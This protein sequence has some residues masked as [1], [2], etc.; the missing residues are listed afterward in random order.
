[1]PNLPTTTNLCTPS[2]CGKFIATEDYLFTKVIF[3]LTPTS[4]W[5]PGAKMNKSLSESNLIDQGTSEPNVT[6][7]NFVSNRA[8]KRKEDERSP[9]DLS[10]SSPSTDLN[11]FCAFKEE[12]RGMFASLLAAQR[13]EFSNINPTLMKIQETNA[14]IETSIEY[15]QK[16]NAEL[17]KKIENLEQQKKED[18]K[19]I[20]VLEEKIENMQKIYRKANIEIKNV[21][22]LEKETKDDL[23]KYTTSLAT[24]VGASI[25]KS[26]IKDIYRVRVQK[27]TVSNAP[28]VV[29]L[30]STLLKS[31]VLQ[32]CKAFNT[33]NKE[34]LRAKHL[35]FVVTEETAVFVS[36]QLTPKASRLYFLARDLIKSTNFTFCWTAYGNVYVR[37]NENSPI[38]SITNEA[39]IKQLFNTA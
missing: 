37:K 17:K 30:T 31:D 20:F 9:V 19:N 12:M 23:I 27:A 22:K 10:L 36:E 4:L 28:I 15:L 25:T 3:V 16:E 29:E 39:Q 7:P 5:S 21:P 2:T 32:K 38:I 33:R 13:Q 18:A 6:P 24:T 35:G 8:K 1:M 11:D 26:D 14:K 34:K